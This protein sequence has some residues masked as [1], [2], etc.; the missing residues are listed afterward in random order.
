MIRLS[1]L[2]KKVKVISHQCVGIKVE[3]ISVLIVQEL[4]KEHFEASL[5][6][7]DPLS[8]ILSGD[9]MIQDFNASGK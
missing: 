7:K 2:N 3:A 8:S 5:L 9:D 6:K 4:V 1:D